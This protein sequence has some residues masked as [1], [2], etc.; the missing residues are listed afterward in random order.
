MLLFYAFI[1]EREWILEKL[2]K[3]HVKFATSK[4]KKFLEKWN[5]RDV[6]VLILNPMSASHGLNLHENGARIMVWSSL[7]FDA[8]L[9]AQGCARLIRTGQ[10][11]GVQIH[12]FMALNTM[13]PKK[14][15]DLNKKQDLLQ[16]F[17]DITK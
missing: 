10:N 14:Y 17:I 13:E 6:D 4:D 8:E 1:E 7:P 15:T 11:R 3:E 12:S 2:K 16:E 9:W 5:K